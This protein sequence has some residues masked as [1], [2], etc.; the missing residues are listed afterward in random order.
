MA[1]PQTLAF[2]VQMTRIESRIV[3]G[4][5]EFI[6]HFAK[7]GGGNPALFQATVTTDTADQYAIGQQL[8]L[9]FEQ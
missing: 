7:V 5:F 9:T 6:Y 3:D 1:L 4:K 2:A 8:T